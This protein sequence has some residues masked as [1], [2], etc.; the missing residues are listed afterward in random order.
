[1]DNELLLNEHKYVSVWNQ[2]ILKATDFPPT[3]LIDF[4]FKGVTRTETLD[5]EG[6]VCL[7][8][9]ESDLYIT[10]QVPTQFKINDKRDSGVDYEAT[11]K[12]AAERTK[13]H[14]ASMA[15]LLEVEAMRLSPPNG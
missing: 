8:E 5:A 12:L 13:A 9:N 1:M 14:L 2:R 10:I 11:V 7:G 3:V 4:G 15:Q 6:N